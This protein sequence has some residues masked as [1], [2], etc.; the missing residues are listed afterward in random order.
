MQPLADHR[1]APL[2]PLAFRGGFDGARLV[3]VLRGLN[4]DELRVALAWVQVAVVDIVLPDAYGEI[5]RCELKRLGTR[6]TERAAAATG[7]GARR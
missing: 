3:L 2:D 7:A 6:H 1:P 4:P 5:V